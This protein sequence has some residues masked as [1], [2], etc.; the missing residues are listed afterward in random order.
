MP[1]LSQPHGTHLE[2]ETWNSPCKAFFLVRNKSF[3]KCFNILS[4][5]GSD[6]Y[7]C[8]M[9]KMACLQKNHL[10]DW[11]GCRKGQQSLRKNSKALD[12][13]AFFFF[14]LVLVGQ[15]LPLFLNAGGF[16]TSALRIWRHFLFAG[17]APH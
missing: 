8:L 10:A 11:D 5:G 2:E 7:L 9:E 12:A 3:F 15:L 1:P 14:L 16:Q 6:A 13:P 17:K 4:V